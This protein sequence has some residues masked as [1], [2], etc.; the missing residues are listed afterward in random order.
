[1]AHWNDKV[2]RL[3]ELIRD[4]LTNDTTGSAGSA[5]RIPIAGVDESGNSIAPTF[6]ADISRLP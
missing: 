3:L 6:N 4:N 1:M 5:D 2:I